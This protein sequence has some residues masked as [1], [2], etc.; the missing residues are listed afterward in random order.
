VV[1]GGS[2]GI[3]LATAERLAAEAA[4]VFIVGRSRAKLDEAVAKIGGDATA[5]RGDVS[6]EEDL[7]R[8]YAEIA[9]TKNGV[10]I[11]FANAAVFGFAPLGRIAGDLIDEVFG[12]NLKG[13]ILTSRRPCRCWPTAVR[14]Y[15][16]ITLEELWAAIEAACPAASSRPAVVA[17]TDLAAV[18]DVSSLGHLGVRLRARRQCVPQAPVCP[19]R[20]PG[21]C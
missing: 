7:D 1:T 8:L 3:G 18:P 12:V 6:R 16:A 4:S 20:R 13:V 10:D 15:D 17:V 21:T 5:V 9:A 19:V 11:A 14:S 2:S